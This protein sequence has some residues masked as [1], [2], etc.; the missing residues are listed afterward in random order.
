MTTIEA[1]VAKILE[2]AAGERA[3]GNISAAKSHEEQA[4]NLR[5]KYNLKP[6]V[7]EIQSEEQ[8]E[9]FAWLDRLPDVQQ[10]NVWTTVPGLNRPVQRAMPLS[11]ARQQIKSGAV[12]WAANNISPP[13]SKAF[14]AHLRAHGT[15]DGHKPL[16]QPM[17]PAQ[18]DELRQRGP[19]AEQSHFTP[20]ETD[21]R[22]APYNK[23]SEGGK[24]WLSK[25]QF[26]N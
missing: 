5:R 21:D 26:W 7:A 1:K 10:V 25:F 6:S 20:H 12:V 13:A 8:S 14:I 3:L 18:L 24:L 2:Q 15:P 17:T 19:T 9:F 16:P 22:G 4:A 23:P 11:V